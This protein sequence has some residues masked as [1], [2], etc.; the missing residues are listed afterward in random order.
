MLVDGVASDSIIH[1]EPYRVEE[2]TDR[3]QA[4]SYL[5]PSEP[6]DLLR[7]DRVRIAEQEQKAD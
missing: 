2:G 5:C 1:R 6:A 4:R 7:R 3:R